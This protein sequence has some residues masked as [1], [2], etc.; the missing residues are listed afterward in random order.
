MENKKDESK[1]ILPDIKNIKSFETYTLPSKGLIYNENDNIPAS[2]TLR[3]MTSKEDKIRL[4][5]STEDRIRRDLLQACITTE[6]VKADNLKLLDANYLLFRL[7]SLSLLD[8]M[9]KVQ[10]RCRSCGST[11]IHEINLSEVPVNYLTK[12]NLNKLKIELPLS[13][14]KVQ[15]KLPSLGNM[16][17]MGDTLRDYLD[18]E[19]NAD[20]NEAIDT[21]TTMLYVDKVNDEHLISEELENWLDAMD[22]LDYRHLNKSIDIVDSLFG[23]ERNLKTQ[24]PKCKT[25]ITHGLPITGELFNPSL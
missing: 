10:L 15:L 4:R 17:T 16:I 12:S 6:N 11:F 22:I 19:P 21:L 2:I 9:Y 14:Q 1:V 8:D 23:F 25:E 7:R 5:N 13:K 20:R 24:C 18:R 3:R